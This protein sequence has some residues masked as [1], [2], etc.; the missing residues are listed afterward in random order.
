MTRR[1]IALEVQVLD[2]LWAEGLVCIVWQTV[3]QKC[4]IGSMPTFQAYYNGKLLD[5]VVGADKVKLETLIQR[6]V[7]GEDHLEGCEFW[8][9]LPQSNVPTHRMLEGKTSPS[10]PFSGFVPHFGAA[11]ISFRTVCQ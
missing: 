9:S 1:T 8:T 7:R 11:V 2:V 3:A 5:Q 10:P 6:L 4:G